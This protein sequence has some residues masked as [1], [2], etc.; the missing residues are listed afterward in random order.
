MSF[1]IYVNGERHPLLSDLRFFMLDKFPPAYVLYDLQTV[2]ATPIEIHSNAPEAGVTKRKLLPNGNYAALMVGPNE[3]LYLSHAP[4]CLFVL[5]VPTFCTSA[6]LW[7]LFSKFG[8]VKEAYVIP[9]PGTTTCNGRGVVVFYDPATLQTIPKNLPFTP[10]FP[11]DELVLEL[12]YHLPDPLKKEDEPAERR[13]NGTW[14]ADDFMSSSPYCMRDRNWEIGSSPHNNHPVSGGNVSTSDLGMDGGKP[15]YVEATPFLSSPPFPMFSPS[16]LRHPPAPS[17]MAI[18][19]PISSSPCSGAG[20]EVSSLCRSSSF[21]TPSTAYST[22]SPLQPPMPVSF[23]SSIGSLHTVTTPE[24]S[25]RRKAPKKAVRNG[26]LESPPTPS[27]PSPVVTSLHSP[28]SHGYFQSGFQKGKKFE[29][30]SEGGP[31]STSGTSENFFS[32]FCVSLSSPYSQNGYSISSS[33]ASPPTVER[34]GC[35]SDFVMPARIPTSDRRVYVV[36]FSSDKE[37]KMAVH[38]QYFFPLPSSD[39]AQWTAGDDC[40][41]YRPCRSHSTSSGEENHGNHSTMTNET[42]P[43]SSSLD[44]PVFAVFTIR[45]R[46][47][48][49]GVA[50]VLRGIVGEALPNTSP[51]V[52]QKESGEERPAIRCALQWICESV[53]API[54][55][56]GGELSEVVSFISGTELRPALG[57]KILDYMRQCDNSMVSRSPFSHS[58][59]VHHR[60]SAGRPEEYDRM[61]QQYSRKFQNFGRLPSNRN[62]IMYPRPNDTLQEKG[63]V[64]LEYASRRRGGF[65]VRRRGGPVVTERANNYYSEPVQ[66]MQGSNGNNEEMT[67]LPSTNLSL[68]EENQLPPKP[69]M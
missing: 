61:D 63:G 27:P 40:H 44:V 22:G 46:T 65:R 50:R 12:G 10:D 41:A 48:F 5:R 13:P 69:I 42:H 11:H 49:F 51:E 19:H 14:G 18:S 39:L 47:A 45:N 62:K 26:V 38:E 55:P 24:I 17:G 56:H 4:V 23:P 37:A 58:S 54:L 28:P 67:F 59:G 33:S 32:P 25:R 8:D 53:N 64:P 6:M 3:E 68:M 57:E 35:M 7:N 29:E 2:P 30:L 66:G 20:K 60:P 21:L 43:T 15:R 16:P 36:H 9:N 1:F 34:S 31:T 52:T